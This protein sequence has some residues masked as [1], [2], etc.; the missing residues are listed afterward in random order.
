MFWGCSALFGAVRRCFSRHAASM[1]K[2]STAKVKHDLAAE[3]HQMTAASCAGMK[4]P[5]RKTLWLSD[6]KARWEKICRC[7]EHTLS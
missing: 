2:W 3:G 1:L 4:R 6:K 7:V 5:G